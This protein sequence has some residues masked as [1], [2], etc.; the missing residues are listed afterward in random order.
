MKNNDFFQIRKIAPITTSLYRSLNTP[1][2]AIEYFENLQAE[3]YSPIL[4]SALLTSVA[5]AYCDMRNY[6]LGK[7]YA[8][9]AYAM[10][11]WSIEIAN[12]YERIKNEA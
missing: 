11:G 5:A 6:T 10:D 4:S 3:Y 1:D 9:R 8:D 12:L 2:K 7:K